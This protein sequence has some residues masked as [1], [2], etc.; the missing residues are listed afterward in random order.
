MHS[1]IAKISFLHKIFMLYST[2]VHVHIPVKSDL[3]LSCNEQIF[4]ILMSTF[5]FISL[6]DSEANEDTLKR[7]GPIMHALI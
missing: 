2:N 6:S 1:Q 3:S 5:Q 4:L 7:G